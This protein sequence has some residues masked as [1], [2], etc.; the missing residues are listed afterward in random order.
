MK[1]FW[2]TPLLPTLEYPLLPAIKVSP[3]E[4]NPLQPQWEFR[5][6]KD[7]LVTFTEKGQQR[8][9]LFSE[10]CSET[11]NVC[12]LFHAKNS[13]DLNRKW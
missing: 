5:E 7:S 13:C 6:C 9:G 3:P 1:L 8:I 10:Y 2:L 11:K 12:Y 4:A